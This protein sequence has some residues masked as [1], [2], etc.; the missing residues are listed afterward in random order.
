MGNRMQT[1]TEKQEAQ[2]TNLAAFK[3]DFPGY[4]VLTF[5]AYKGKR[6][7]YIVPIEAEDP[8]H[9]HRYTA[10]NLEHINGYLY[11][12]VQ[13]ACGQLRRA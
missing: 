12:A 1:L 8:W 7:F 4:E 11:W 2:L 3:A 6:F 5:K 9:D 13:A 10:D